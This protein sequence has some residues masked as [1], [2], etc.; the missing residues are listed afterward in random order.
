MCIYIYIYGD[1]GAMIIIIKE[2][3]ELMSQVQILNET[4]DISLTFGKSMSLSLLSPASEGLVTSLGEG[5]LNSN[6]LPTCHRS[7]G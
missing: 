4:D 7:A 6:H 5:K 2:I 1:E 3:M